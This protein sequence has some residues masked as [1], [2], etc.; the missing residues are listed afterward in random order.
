MEKEMS[1]KIKSPAIGQALVEFALLLPIL[2][3][4]VLG[5]IEF[6]RIFLLYTEASNA[7]R[8]AARYGVAAGDS[9]NSIARFLDCAEIRQ[10]ALD[11]TVLSDFTPIE[12]NIEIAYDKP[13]GNSTKIVGFCDDGLAEND[14]QQGYRIVVTVTAT[15]EPILPILPI[16]QF[17]FSPS[18]RRTILKDIVIENEADLPPP[19]PTCRL[20]QIA[21]NP[22]FGG[23][24]SASPEPNCGAT[25][26]QKDTDVTLTALPNSDYNFTFWTVSPI[27]GS[28]SGTS[29]PV[30]VIKMDDNYTAIANFSAIICHQIVTTLNPGN[31]AGSV[32]VDPSTPENCPN[33]TGWTEGSPVIL[34]VFENVG[35]SFDHWN[36]PGEIYDASPNNPLI[37][38][39]NELDHTLNLE[40]EFTFTANC[41]GIAEQIF[42]NGEG[43]INYNPPV[44]TDCPGG[45]LDG[46]DVTI[47]AVPN[48]PLAYEFTVWGLDAASNGTTNPGIITVD[49]DKTISATFSQIADVA[50]IFVQKSDSVDP[51]TVG[52]QFN[53]TLVVGNNGPD[54]AGDVRVQDTLPA[55]LTPI[56]ANASQGS[57]N[58]GG[59]V[60]NCTIGFISANTNQTVDI[61]VV[62]NQV[63]TIQ[64][65]AIVFNNDSGQIDTNSSNN[66]DSETTQ[67]LPAGDLGISKTGPA[68][69]NVGGTLTYNIV[70]SNTGPSNV[71]SVVVVDALPLTVNYLSSS[72]SVGACG[73][74]G[75]QVICNLGDMPANGTPVNITINAIAVAAST[76]VNQVNVSSSTSDPNP[77]NNTATAST[78]IGTS[79][80]PFITMSP[81]CAPPGGTVTVKGYNW[82]FNGNDNT[83]IYW[84]TVGGTVLGTVLDSIVTAGNGIWAKDVTVPLTAI[85]GVRTIVADR[86]GSG[87]AQ[88]NAVVTVPC[89]APDLEISSNIT[90]LNP[91]PINQGDPVSFRVSITNT[92]V[93]PAISLFPVS[94]Y[95]NPSPTPT[96]ST[97][98]ITS[99]FKV[100]SSSVGGLGVGASRVLTLTAASG[101]PITGTNSVY[102]VVDSDGPPDGVIDEINEF[103]NLSSGLT[104]EV[105]PCVSNCGGGPQTGNGI[106]AGQVFVPSIS[107]E[108]LPQ[109]NVFVFLVGPV[110][111]QTAYTFSNDNGTY[112]FQNLPTGSYTVSGCIDIDGVSYFLDLPVNVVT[113]LV[114]QQDLILVQGPCS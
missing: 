10:A 100:A 92:G 17:N 112:V 18:S 41:Y 5:V 90:L 48:E 62:P 3:L 14:I 54:S 79:G 64:N 97:T 75:T 76:A 34:N 11:T 32:Q 108:L 27:P 81:T 52:R 40:A 31:D 72:T 77:A 22:T 33:N 50:D 93:S 106:L 73:Q 7:A 56:S 30:K 110:I 36:A 29:N 26:Y 4:L 66:F 109:P 85:Y 21:N 39:V 103:N 12:D 42:P 95:F 88:D 28:G 68:T 25:W 19:P 57:C 86:T 23:T 84:E 89:P 38:G 63:G 49:G 13:F 101:F 102:A 2:L 44:G 20:L 45:W 35:Y 46:T 74:S 71:A 55:T 16:P 61:V 94:I 91:V 53:Y 82:P 1:R 104:V 107:G 87:P 43:I 99:T 47:T 111:T 80:T 83:T 9:P 51:A 113:G 59:N 96:G 70:V 37:I 69:A 67:I 15:F 105:D 78:I 58:I 6:G 114:T 8:E 65:T 60:V 24:V 98:H